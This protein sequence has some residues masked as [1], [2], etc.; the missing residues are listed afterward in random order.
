VEQ[1][2]PP[3][4]NT[5]DGTFQSWKENGEKMV[6]LGSKNIRNLKKKKENIGKKPTKSETKKKTLHQQQI[7]EGN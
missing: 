2:R 1:N 4:K 7:A 5:L 6:Q 3:D